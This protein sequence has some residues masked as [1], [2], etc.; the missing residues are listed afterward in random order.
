MGCKK[1]GAKNRVIVIEKEKKQPLLLLFLN[2]NE[3]VYSTLLFELRIL[4]RP[5]FFQGHKTTHVFKTRI[6]GAGGL[7]ESVHLGH[8][9][10]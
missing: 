2:N 8:C 4:Q 5:I 7:G 9:C 6:V 3:P 10:L 1:Q